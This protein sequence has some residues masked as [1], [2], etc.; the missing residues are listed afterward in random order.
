MRFPLE[1]FAALRAYWPQDMPMGVRLSATD[2]IEGGWDL[3]Q[4]VTLKG[5]WLC[6]KYEIPAMLASGG[7]SI[8]NI[9]S[10]SGVRGEALQSPYSAAKGGV[11]ALTKTAAA[12]ERA[13][14]Y[15]RQYGR[16]RRHSDA[17]HYRLFR[18]S[19]RRTGADGEGSRHA[20]PG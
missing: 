15:S 2:W 12:G 20:S 5:V 18:Q 13:T 4:S 6:L 8:V 17:G 10:L 16:S 11:I 7:G 1:I 9:A 19:T 14:Q 3:A